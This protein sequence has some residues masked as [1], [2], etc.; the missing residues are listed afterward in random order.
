MFNLKQYPYTALKN[1]F[2]QHGL[3]SSFVKALPNKSTFTDSIEDFIAT[4]R[5]EN[6]IRI[7]SRSDLINI[8]TASYDSAIS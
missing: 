8:I 1:I 5:F 3:N 7:C 4:G 2:S 6:N